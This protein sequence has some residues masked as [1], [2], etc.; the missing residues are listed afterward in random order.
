M[1]SKSEKFKQEYGATIVKVGPIEPIENSD[2][3]GQTSI[4]NFSVVVRKDQIKEGDILVYAPIETTLN[5]GF[6]RVNNAY[7]M[8]ERALNANYSEVQSLIDA[9]KEDEAKSKVG[10]FNKHGRVR[11]I[12]LRGVQSFGVLFPPEAF[13]LWMPE[14][15]DL[16]FSEHVGEDFDTIG[17][18][19]WIKVWV[20]KINLPKSFRRS[21]SKKQRTFD[22]IIPE[23][24]KFHYDTTQLQRCIQFIPPTAEVTVSVKLHGTSNI[25]GNV[26]TKNP[27]RLSPMQKAL[28]LHHRKMMKKDPTKR[29]IYYQKLIPGY[30]IGYSFI[31]SSRKVIKNQF[32]TTGKK[33]GFYGT[34]AS[35]E[36]YAQLLKGKIPTGMTVYSEIVGDIPEE[37]LGHI[38]GSYDYGCDPGTC[39]MYPYRIHIRKSG[40]E[41]EYNV[42]DVVKW[43][44]EL[45]KT[46]PELTDWIKPLPILYHGKLMDMYPEIELQD[47]QTPEGGFD[48][49]KYTSAVL[50]AM[51]EDKIR[52]GM[53]LN[54]PLCKNKVPREGIVLRIDND[55]VLEAFKLKTD[56]FFNLE[57]SNID[58][59]I[60][61]SEMME[62]Y[63]EN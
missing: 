8:H 3:L 53:E 39:C 49:N 36:K 21:G 11:T 1:F 40:S 50:K 58:K 62:G 4:N 23:E 41:T 15:K 18:K 28:N 59:G 31:Y 57:A 16:D 56:K 46:Y 35:W 54:E 43:T 5:A 47:Y 44:N 60:I 14:T 19:L 27:R 13:H 33:P 61:D 32:A 25:D 17:N 63:I 26:L 51:K 2:F 29:S 24:W 30:T 22:R 38:Q 52:L 48:Q 7:E 6:L 12:R 34:D 9:G 37:G 20:P 10:F 42:L 55:P 45:L